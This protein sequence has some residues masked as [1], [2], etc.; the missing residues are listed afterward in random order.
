L[1]KDL[2][3][4][5]SSAIGR[6]LWRLPWYLSNDIHRC[7]SPTEL[8]KIVTDSLGLYCPFFSRQLSAQLISL[9]ET[10]HHGF[11]VFRLGA[12]VEQVPECPNPS[13]EIRFGATSGQPKLEKWNGT[14]SPVRP[15]PMVL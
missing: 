2:P 11:G 12:I 5:V 7:G 9:L 14:A 6:P 3:I 1:E 4:A 10:F 8:G 13:R 15:Q